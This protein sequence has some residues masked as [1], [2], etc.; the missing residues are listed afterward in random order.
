[1]VMVHIDARERAR[2]LRKGI[3]RGWICSVLNA[4]QQAAKKRLCD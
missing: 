3:T 4:L 2:K 1:M